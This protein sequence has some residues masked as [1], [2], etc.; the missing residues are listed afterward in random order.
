MTT[1]PLFS[2][3]ASI[4]AGECQSFAAPGLQEKAT[5]VVFA[6]GAAECGV[7][8]GGLGTGYLELRSDEEVDHFRGHGA[9]GSH[10]GV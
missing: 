1:E 2:N 10:G 5:G 6:D 9:P 4:P 3:L 8:L 7:P